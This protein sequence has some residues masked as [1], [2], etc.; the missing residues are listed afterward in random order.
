M[1]RILLA[2]LLIGCGTDVQ[3]VEP[4]PTPGPGPG[5]IPGNDKT[6]FQEITQLHQT[7]CIQCHA[8]S[9]FV[10]SESL[11]KASTAKQRVQNGSMPPPNGPRMGDADRQKYLNFFSS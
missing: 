3:T 9:G 5:P 2:L 6:T 4:T 8:N 7:Y 1:K 11:L 10:R